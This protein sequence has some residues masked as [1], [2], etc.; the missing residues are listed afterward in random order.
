MSIKRTLTERKF[1]DAYIKCNGN[2]AEAYRVTHPKYKG[3]NA[4]VMGCRKLTKVNLETTELLNEMDMTD[5]QLHQK[6]KEGL[7]SKKS[8]IV[9]NKLLDVDDFPTRQKYLDMA[10]KLKGT[11]PAEKHEETRKVIILGKKE[12]KEDEQ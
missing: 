5:Q 3:E 12:K 4:K 10:Y 7:D 1:I 2:A 11:Y 9:K 6:L 8:I